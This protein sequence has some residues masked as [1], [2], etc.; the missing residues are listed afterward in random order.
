V[1]AKAVRRVL[2]L[3]GLDRV[4]AF[5]ISLDAAV[6]AAAT[7]ATVPVTPHPADRHAAGP[8]KP[9]GRAGRS[10]V[11][12]ALRQRTE[13]WPAD[14]GTLTGEARA[15]RDQ[16]ARERG[17]HKPGPSALTAA[18]LRV[19]PLL[20]THL[21]GPEIAAEMFLSRHTVKSHQLSLYRKLGVTSRS[22]AV[23]RARDLGLLER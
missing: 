22:G 23:A 7:T 15:V 18:E 3:N 5:Y 17:S 12:T 14:L 10:P 6:A 1:T 16:L 20:A 11:P 8:R 13:G 21:S 9:A 2:T 19:L 4:I